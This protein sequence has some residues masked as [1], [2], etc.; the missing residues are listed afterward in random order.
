MAHYD[1]IGSMSLTIIEV[2]GSWA[3]SKRLAHYMKVNYGAT[4]KLETYLG[5]EK[6][7]HLRRFMISGT[8]RGIPELLHTLTNQWKEE[9]QQQER[10]VYS[11]KD[12]I[13]H[14]LQLICQEI[15]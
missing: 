14:R 9:R 15:A 10:I 3:L 11:S 4:T 8:H 6:K 7:Y 5:P 12:I 2:K 13:K 1:F